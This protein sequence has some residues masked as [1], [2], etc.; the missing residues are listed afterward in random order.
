LNVSRRSA[1]SQKR[2]SLA[3]ARKNKKT[4]LP[5]LLQ[6]SEIAS[7]ESR[8]HFLVE[9]AWTP[10]TAREGCALTVVL[11][12]SAPQ[13]RQARGWGQCRKTPA[14]ARDWRRFFL[15]CNKKSRRGLRSF[16]TSIVMAALRVL[17]AR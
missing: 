5:A 13:N 1:D 4:L 9:A 14:T 8:G 2:P 17:R 3:R 6:G 10:T 12:E 7:C 16:R 11:T 15:L